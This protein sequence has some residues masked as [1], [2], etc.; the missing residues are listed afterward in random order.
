LVDDFGSYISSTDDS[1]RSEL[2]PFK[3]GVKHLFKV[4][5]LPITLALHAQNGPPKLAPDQPGCVDSKVF[6]KLL[7]CR[8]DNCEKKD[9]DHRD[10]SVGE[11]EKGQVITA[12]IDGNSRAV[13]YECAEGTTPATIVDQAAKALKAAGFEVPYQFADAEASLTARKDDMWVTV[14]AASRFYTLTETSAVAMDFDATDAASLSEMIERYGHVPVGGIQFQAGRAELTPESDAIL[15]EV[16]TLMND[17][18]TWRLR[19]EGHTD[20][21][22]S[23]MSNMTLSFRRASA[24]VAWLT[25]KGIKRARLDPQGIGDARPVADNNTEEGRQKNRRIELVKIPSLPGQ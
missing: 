17:H 3:F 21:T 6:P 2:I 18:P 10:V 25:S 13:M 1:V 5:F 8:I 4:L 23:K 20:N 11:N 9:S 12:S 22:G 16:A 7:A 24:V 19:V 15:A 14:E